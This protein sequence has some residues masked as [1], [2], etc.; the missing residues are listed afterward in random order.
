MPKCLSETTMQISGDRRLGCKA[1]TAIL[2]AYEDQAS[3]L[4]WH[5]NRQRSKLGRP[6]LELK[7]TVPADVKTL[8]RGMNRVYN[9]PHDDSSGS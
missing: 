2:R 1:D 7:E 9:A 4:L 3:W 6:I 8:D 5:I